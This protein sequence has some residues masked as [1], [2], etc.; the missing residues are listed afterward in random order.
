[1]AFHAAKETQVERRRQF[2]ASYSGTLCDVFAALAMTLAFRRWTPADV[3]PRAGSKYRHEAGQ[4]LRV[5]RIVEVIRPMGLT[6]NEIL[7]DSPCRVSL[8]CRWRI[9]PVLGSSAVRLDVKYRLNH[10]A[11]L[12]FRHW[13]RRLQV[14][15]GK[16]LRFIGQN[17][18][19]RLE[20]SEISQARNIS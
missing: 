5:G 14:H 4:V 13:E 18:E 6:L 19:R 12:R 2:R 9:E 20:P 17:L 3:L 15:F 8:L 16:Q 1:V 10:A 7:Y 11:S